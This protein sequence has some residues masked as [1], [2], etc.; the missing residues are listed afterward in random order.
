MGG[1]E[2]EEWQG[3]V[4]EDREW[5]KEAVGRESSHACGGGWIDEN[6]KRETYYADDGHGETDAGLGEAETAGEMEGGKVCV[7]I[8][9][10]WCG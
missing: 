1:E 4:C 6:L 10:V 9:I 3:G 2:N 7:L 5:E 8:V